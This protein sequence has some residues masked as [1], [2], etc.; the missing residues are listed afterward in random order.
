[1]LRRLLTFLI[2]SIGCANLY[3]QDVKSPYSSIGLGTLYGTPNAVNSGMGGIG[4][5]TPRL[6]TI[7]D[8]NP[9]LLPYN[10]HTTFQVGAVYESRTIEGKG[11]L[12]QNVEVSNSDANLA[13][14]GLAF[15]V[16][17]KK[18]T[19]A[20]GLK[21]YSLVDYSK[22]EEH[23]IAQVSQNGMPTGQFTSVKMYR[24]MTGSGGINRAYLAL[25]ARIFKGLNIGVTGNLYFGTI[26]RDEVNVLVDTLGASSNTHEQ[27]KAI[28]PQFASAY[29]EDIIFRQFKLDFGASYLYTLNEHLL[30]HAGAVYKIGGNLG[31]Q[32]VHKLERRYKQSEDSQI[33]IEKDVSD[34]DYTLKFPGELSLGISFMNPVKW[35]VGADFSMSDWSKYENPITD[36]EDFL[37][38]SFRVALG[39]E[40]TPDYSSIKNYLSRVTYRLGT[41]YEQTPYVVSGTKIDDWGATAGFS[42][43]IKYSSLDF[44]FIFG[45]RG[46]LSNDTYKETYFQLKLGVTFGDPSWFIKRKYD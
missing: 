26:N 23:K 46:T 11:L 40:Y 39:G 2:I 44:A 15:P 41:F 3:A 38:K 20:I 33:N 10:T 21:P 28:A 1:M 27:N 6:N 32:S 8:A 25:G 14:L 42:M 45:Q 24:E 29:T 43:P 22:K 18:V 19:M 5:A 34:N 7:N 9:A 31:A 17:R 37:G 16:V 4:V 35:K 30:M 13:Y 12:G 36:D